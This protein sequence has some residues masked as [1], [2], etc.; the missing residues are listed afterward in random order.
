MGRNKFGVSDSKRYSARHVK[1]VLQEIGV[2]IA[3]ETSHDFLCYC[4]VH[5]NRNTPSMSVSKTKDGYLCFNADC[6]ASGNLADLVSRVTGRNYFEASRLL[7]S[8]QPNEQ[9]NFQED[10]QIVLTPEPEFPE[11]SQE[12]L[13]RMYLDIKAPG[14]DGA[15]YLHGRGFTDDTIDYFKVGYSKKK[16]MVAVPMH[17]PAGKPVGVVGRS[18]AGKT[19]K[20]SVGLPTS[21]TFFNLHRA[22]RIGPACIITEASFDA[23]AIKQAGFPNVVA[24]LSSKVSDVK[25]KLLDRHFD[26]IIIFA[27]NRDIDAAGRAMGNIIAQHFLNRKEILWAMYNWEEVYP[28]NL[29]DPSAILENLGEEAVAECVHNAISHFEYASSMV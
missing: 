4:P 18:I 19:F 16:D 1:T 10:L 14:N 15:K 25:L 11:F 29:K 3:S 20:N 5:D 27:D 6:G 24:N 17:S 2:R 13:D 22:R 28:D 12:V 26:K 8:H 21:K 7:L 9:D 23:M